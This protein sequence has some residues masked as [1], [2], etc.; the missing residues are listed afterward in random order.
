MVETVLISKIKPNP[1]PVA[2]AITAPKQG[3]LVVFV[4]GN[5][6]HSRVGDCNVIGGADRYA[7]IGLA[8]RSEHRTLQQNFT[9]LCVAWLDRLAKLTD[10]EYD[11]PMEASVEFARK[12]TATEAY[13]DNKYL[14][15]I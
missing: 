9:R 2:T 12:L 15:T 10:S 14:P 7:D 4:S 13:Q 8:L 11:L 6:K 1:F 3:V 5:E